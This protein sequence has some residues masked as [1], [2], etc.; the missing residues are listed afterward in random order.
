VKINITKKEYH[1]L[2]DI[3][4]IAD[5][6]INAFAMDERVEAKEYRE[7]EQKFFAFAKDFGAD[8]LIELDHEDGQ[9]YPSPKMDDETRAM[10]FINEF[11]EETLWDELIDRLALRDLVEQHGSE[12]TKSILKDKKIF[13]ELE[14]LKDKYSKEFENHGI[15][16]L[17]LQNN[18]E[19]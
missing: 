15:E 16:N 9:F 11:E 6:I 19:A 12:I 10:K 4:Y 5:W 14:N 17:R 2:L 18:K 13:K 3:L 8:D 1:T 7:L